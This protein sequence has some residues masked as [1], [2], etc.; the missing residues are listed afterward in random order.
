[1]TF[2]DEYAHLSDYELAVEHLQVCAEH[3]RIEGEELHCHG[4][5]P[6]QVEGLPSLLWRKGDRLLTTEAAVEQVWAIRE[7]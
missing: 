7:S 1:V 3:A 5:E 4:Y 6:V 2:R